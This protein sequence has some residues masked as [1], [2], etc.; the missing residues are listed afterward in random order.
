MINQFAFFPTPLIK[1]GV[2]SLSELADIVKTFGTKI[3][4]VTGSASLQQSGVLIGIEAQCSDASIRFK[5]IIVTGE[6]TTEFIDATVADCGAFGADAIAAIG[7][8]SVLDAGKAI[9]A[10]LCE[11][12]GVESYLDGGPRKPSGRKIPFV[13]VP[14]TAGT[15]SEATSNAL[16]R[17]P[18]AHGVKKSL[19][20]VNYI[21]D[22]AVIDPGLMTGCPAA[23]TA[24]CGM[25][26]F[27]QLL[28]SFV[29]VKASP[30][31]DALV[32]SGIA[33]LRDNLPAAAVTRPR[34]LE[35]RAG[36]AY[37][38]LISG[39]TLANAGLGVVHGMAGVI[40]AL[41]AVPHGVVCG[42]L[43]GPATKTTIKLLRAIDPEHPA[44]LKYASMG[45]FLTPSESGFIEPSFVSKSASSDRKKA[46]M[47]EEG[48][49]ALLTTIASWTER[50]RIPSLSGYGVT[51]ADIDRIVA[52]SGNRNNPVNLDRDNIGNVVSEAL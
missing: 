27:T 25:D 50:L 11:D 2:G 4:L 19:R 6:P 5:H 14:T 30:L 18:G 48:C 10:M 20:H 12:G 24:A 3:L 28:E 46:S 49:D 34:D 52:G 47:I 40:G 36:M 7:G 8:G 43:V 17:A 23:V 31:T 9:S 26:A 22:A 35:A 13:A 15:G 38:A 42:R 33:A 1:F 29:S 37:A 45:F 21:P 44:L 41:F 32:T 51:K 16:L 39:I